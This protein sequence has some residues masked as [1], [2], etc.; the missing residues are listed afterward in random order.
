MSILSEIPDALVVPAGLP[1]LEPPR[2]SPEKAAA[3]RVGGR[4]EELLPVPAEFGRHIPYN[5]LP[6]TPRSHLMLRAG[7]IERLTRASG[8]LPEPFAIAVLD[9]WRSVDYQ[10]ELLAYYVDRFPELTAGYIAD[11]DD[12]LVLPP[13]TTGGA[14]DLTLRWNGIDLALGTDYDSFAE[15]A[16]L[17]TLEREVGD[18]RAR[19]LRRL[20]SSVLREAGF[21]PYPMEWWHWSYGDQWW[22]AEYGHPVSLYGQQP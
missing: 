18:H 19:E 17:V 12:E 9:G 13:H 3:V 8:L 7:V 21:A 4:E 22:A 10:R 16:H 1:P 6:V 15:T 2:S 5:A 11:P 20:L 14:V